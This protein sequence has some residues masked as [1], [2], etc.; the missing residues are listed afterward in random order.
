MLSEESVQQLLAS[1]AGLRD[2]ILLHLLYLSGLRVSE[3]IALRWRNLHSRDNAGIIVVYGKGGRTRSIALPAALWLELLGLR[4]MASA[5]R[6]AAEQ[7]GI[8]ELVSPHWL[9][10]AQEHRLLSPGL[11][12]HSIVGASE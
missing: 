11:A 8:V 7:A 10:H 3:A 4:G 9:R 12:S 2:R 6:Q 1:D 5:E